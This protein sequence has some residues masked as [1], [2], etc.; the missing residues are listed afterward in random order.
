VLGKG[1]RGDCDPCTNLLVAI[2]AIE[3]NHAFRVRTVYP[4][5]RTGTSQ[6]TLTGELNKLASNIAQARN[7]TGLRW[8]SDATQTMLLGEAV[9][10]GILRD[11]I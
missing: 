6:I 2:V 11:Q 5:R 3:V 8:R 4:S 7:I 1:G 10:I 9:A